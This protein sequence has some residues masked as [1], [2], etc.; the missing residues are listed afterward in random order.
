MHGDIRGTY[1][2][3]VVTPEK[4]RETSKGKTKKFTL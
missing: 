2:I 4:E 3:S 1:R